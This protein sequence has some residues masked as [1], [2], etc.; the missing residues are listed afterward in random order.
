MLWY[1]LFPKEVGRHERYRFRI[2][3]WRTAY[4]EPWVGVSGG[5][6]GLSKSTGRPQN[7]PV[8]N[9]LWISHLNSRTKFK[10]L[11][12]HTGSSSNWP[13][14]LASSPAFSSLPLFSSKAKLKVFLCT[15]HLIIFSGLFFLSVISLQNALLL[16]P[17]PLWT[18]TPE[19]ARRYPFLRPISNIT[20][21]GA[22]SSMTSFL[23]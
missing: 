15:I 1:T 7:Y 2:T 16:I 21:S 22:C 4:A 14:P 23:L 9:L 13:L 12:W 17:H 18:P 19:L 3:E 6:G 5:G 10:I 8:W 11:T 20:F